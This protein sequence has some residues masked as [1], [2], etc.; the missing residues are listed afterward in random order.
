MSDQAPGST[1]PVAQAVASLLRSIPDRWGDFDHDALSAAAT[2]ERGL[3]GAR[4]R[5]FRDCHRV[6]AICSSCGMRATR[7]V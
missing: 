7:P 5:G 4:T 1:D 3:A 6:A 2:A